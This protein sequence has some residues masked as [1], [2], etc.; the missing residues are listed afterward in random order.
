[1][2]VHQQELDGDGVDAQGPG[3][4]PPLGG[5]ADHGA[6]GKTQGSCIVGVPLGSGGNAI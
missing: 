1:M 5:T 2:I 6:N 3:G 4:V